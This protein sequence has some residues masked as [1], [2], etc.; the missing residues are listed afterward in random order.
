MDCWGKDKIDIPVQTG[1]RLTRIHRLTPSSF[2]EESG[3]ADTSP[4]VRR[5]RLRP[6]L[7][8]EGCPDVHR[9]GV[10]FS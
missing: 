3:Q 4:L 10:V 8:K 5:R 2:P 7:T 1:I 6:L 9:D